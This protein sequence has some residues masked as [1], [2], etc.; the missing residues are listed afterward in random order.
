[1]KPMNKNLILIGFMGTGKSAVGKALARRLGRKF[2]ELDH[3]IAR[4]ER[5]TIP[6]I[7]AGKGEPYFRRVERR[8]LR[9]AAARRRIVLA[10]GGGAILNPRNVRDLQK[11][12][13][14][15]CLTAKMSEIRKRTSRNPNRPLLQNKNP[16]Q[17]IRNLL[18]YRR[19]LYRRA[20]D[21]FVSTTGKTAGQTA[22]MILKRLQK[23][24]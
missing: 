16:F 9:K 13:I 11:N 17:T 2:L 20:A 24:K 14:L 7:F 5:K 19:P 10:T 15:I 21:F 23:L 18:K 8:E 12:G 22:H 4:S 6:Q 3:Q 1:M